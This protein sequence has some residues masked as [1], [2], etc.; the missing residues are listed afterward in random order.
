MPSLEQCKLVTVGQM[1]FFCTRKHKYGINLQA[2]C[3]HRHRFLD[4]AMLF[5]GS[6]SDL[7]AFETSPIHIKLAEDGFL[8]PGLCI[9]G[10]NAYVNTNYMA[11][12]YPN[13]STT[14]MEKDAYN[15]YHSQVRIN[16][17]CAF[18]ILVQRWG[19]LKK[20][21]PSNYSVQKTI[22]TVECLC[23]LHNFLIDEGCSSPPAQ[24]T[25]EDMFTMT[26]DGAVECPEE[27]MGA[28]EH[29]DD[30]PGYAVRRE[31]VRQVRVTQRYSNS[32][33]PRESMFL[34]V[35]DNNLRRPAR[36][37]RA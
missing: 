35:T 34:S 1:K 21:A 4:I 27:L 29:R 11:T 19:F 23:M 20:K 30:D 13:V 33:L 26:V 36:N 24:H 15:F 28:G 14:N 5:G 7:L 12:P 6:S 17:E 2:I 31:I 18:G 32:L 16:I 10:D 8:A 37:G 9:F 25:N 22:E 3:D